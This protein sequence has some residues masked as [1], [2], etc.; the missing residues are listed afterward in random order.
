MSAKICPAKAV[1]ELRANPSAAWRD[2][3]VEEMKLLYWSG[4]SYAKIA[5]ALAARFGGKYTC[6]TVHR[7]IEVRSF[8]RNPDR[9]R[10]IDMRRGTKKRPLT[11]ECVATKRLSQRRAP[12]VTEAGVLGRRYPVPPGGFSMHAPVL[13]RVT[14]AGS[15]S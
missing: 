10:E 5:V 11:V 4:M 12:E 3:V 13:W 15:G 6:D 7:A 14:K 8:Q 1:A 9:Q 2:D